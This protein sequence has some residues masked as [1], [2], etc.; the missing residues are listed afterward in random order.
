MAF[1]HY[2]VID[3]E[4]YAVPG[5][6]GIDAVR[7]ELLDAVRAGGAYVSLGREGIGYSEVLVTGRTRVRIDHLIAADE[8]ADGE[9]DSRELDDPYWWM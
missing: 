9:G 4:R 5:D 6:D 3:D 8:P 2:V 1:N 7:R